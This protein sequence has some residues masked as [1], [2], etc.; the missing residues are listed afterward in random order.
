MHVKLSLEEASL[1]RWDFIGF[2]GVIDYIIPLNETA[3]IA[4]ATDTD[5]V[6]VL[7]NMGWT[8]PLPNRSFGTIRQAVRAAP[9]NIQRIIIVCANPLTRL[10]MMLTLGRYAD[11]K[12][13]LVIVGSMKKAEEITAASEE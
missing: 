7:V 10:V 12:E 2:I 8:I 13:R 11:L 4:I 5:G 6:V 1:I 3:A 9:S